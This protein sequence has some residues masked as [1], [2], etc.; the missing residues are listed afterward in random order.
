MMYF[1]I[2]C[3]RYISNDLANVGYGFYDI[4]N[5]TYGWHPLSYHVT[6]LT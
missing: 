5:H 3:C 2:E 6:L 4:I 1:E